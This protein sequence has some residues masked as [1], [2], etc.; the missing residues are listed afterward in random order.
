MSFKISKIIK[1]ITIL[2]IF[3]SCS[4]KQEEIK[5]AISLFPNLNKIEIDNSFKDQEIKIP[6]QKNNQFWLSRSEASNNS[7]IENFTFAHQIKKK[8]SINYSYKFLGKN[9][10]TTEPVIDNKTAYLIDHKGRITSLNLQNKKRNWQTKPFKTK[11]RN[12]K[13]YLSNNK[14][15]A[16]SGYN[17]LSAINTEDGS[18]LWTKKLNSIIISSPIVN[19]DLLF[20]ITSDNKTYSL[21]AN[22]GEIIWIH[23]GI[24]KNTAIL[25][26]SE[27]VFYKNYVFSSYSS[28][29]IYILN[30]KN[31]EIGWFYNLNTNR[32][33]DS[34]F[35]LND[36]DNI[37]IIRNDIVYAVGNGGINDGNSN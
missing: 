29:E 10:L 14:I 8:K 1:L 34:D 5:D 15:F 2:L 19:K 21:N 11:F 28:G 17:Y 6:Q 33:I 9:Y 24:D 20:F 27:P 3:S 37:P 32:A 18:T 7:E 26:S 4:S 12:G 22:N 23:E 16:T 35:I 31:G 30:Q 25:G 36:I 13:I